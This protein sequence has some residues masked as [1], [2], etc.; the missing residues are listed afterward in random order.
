VR[1]R[2]VS[3]LLATV[4]LIAIV[5]SAGLVV[6]AML[7]GWMGTYSSTLSVQPTSVDLV[8]AGD[9]ALLSVSVKNTGNRPLAGVVVTG[10]D[11]NGKPFKLAL[12]PAEPGQA[13]GN[14]LVIPLGVSNI[15]LDASGNN[16]HAT[17][18]GSWSWISDAN[19]GACLSLSGGGYVEAYVDVPE[20]DFTIDLFVKTALSNQGVFQVDWNGHDRHFGIVSS[21]L[22]YHRV[23]TG[24]GWTGTMAVNDGKW[25]GWAL[26]VK[27]G[28]GQKAYVDAAPAGTFSYDHSDF[29]WQKTI[30]IGQSYD[31]GNRLN[32]LIASVRYYNK[33]LT[34][35]EVAFNHK[36]PNYPLTK[37]LVF[38]YPL[39]EGTDAP[40]AFTA[41]RVYALTVTAYS[42]DGSITAQALT[43]RA[44]A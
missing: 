15:V 5:V 37:G 31:F 12:S 4:V 32:G 40:Y 25:H 21:G 7:S 35:E 19:F 33:P 26:T 27:T 36:N 2:A 39:S 11:D 43:A 3:P 17:L 29:N 9:K 10:Y 24:A 41:G 14:T 22:I 28:D 16:N 8:I 23:W 13:S 44:T 30:H 38:W 18:I 20:Y 6:Y 1:R 42:L 34:A